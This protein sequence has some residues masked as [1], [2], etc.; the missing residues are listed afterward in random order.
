MEG[1][2]RRNVHEVMQNAINT[3]N[4]I[5]FDGHASRFSGRGGNSLD[6]SPGPGQY[7]IMVS[8]ADD[9]KRVSPIPADERNQS[10]ATRNLFFIS[11]TRKVPG[12]GAYFRQQDASLIRS[13]FN[14][15]LPHNVIALRK[16]E[17]IRSRFLLQNGG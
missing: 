14:V 11:R 17:I 9:M 10:P 16:E 15:T 13:S 8:N 12:P 7:D 6:P 1:K 4:G 5:A 2:D 3:I